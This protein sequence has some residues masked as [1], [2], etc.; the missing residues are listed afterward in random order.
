M[1]EDQKKEVRGSSSGVTNINT[2]L[3][4]PN[5]PGREVA[6]LTTWSSR[7]IWNFCRER[8]MADPT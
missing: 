4:K 3:I 2:C 5:P 6:H 1:F 8:D 7:V